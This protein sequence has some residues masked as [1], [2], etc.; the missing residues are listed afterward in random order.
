VSLTGLDRQALTA[1]GVQA[2]IELP[3]SRLHLVVG[4]DAAKLAEEIAATA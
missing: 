3:P 1:A 4:E 2:L